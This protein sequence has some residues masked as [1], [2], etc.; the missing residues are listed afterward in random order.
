[1]WT[2]KREWLEGRKEVL[3]CSAFQPALSWE[4]AA[5]EKEKVGKEEE[6]EKERE[7]KEVW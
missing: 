7:E 5:K 1:M 4:V 2:R 6:K 3:L